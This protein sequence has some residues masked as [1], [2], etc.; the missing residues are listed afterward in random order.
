[1]HYSA[2][3]VSLTPPDCN[4]A[5]IGDNVADAGDELAFRTMEMAALSLVSLYTYI[6][7]ITTLFA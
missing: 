5:E 6:H 1:M 3:A 4:L 2:E 7:F